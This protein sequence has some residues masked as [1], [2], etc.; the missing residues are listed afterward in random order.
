[1]NT[2]FKNYILLNYKK[3]FQ[4]IKN[5]ERVIYKN[6]KFNYSSVKQDT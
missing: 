5:M 4:N 1:M 6:Q 3:Y 2:L